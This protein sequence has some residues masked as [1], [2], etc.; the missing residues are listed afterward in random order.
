MAKIKVL[1]SIFNTNPLGEQ[2]KKVMQQ[3]GENG[4]KPFSFLERAARKEVRRIKKIDE[5]E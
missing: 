5:E 4:K 2:L 3:Q 1:K